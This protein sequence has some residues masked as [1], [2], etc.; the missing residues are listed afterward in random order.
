MLQASSTSPANNPNAKAK[1]LGGPEYGDVMKVQIQVNEAGVI[2]DAKFK[3]CGCGSAV[4]EELSLPPVKMDCSA[5]A[6]DAIKAAIED[7]KRKNG[8]A[9][10]EGDHAGE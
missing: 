2:T 5:L 6:E 10:A 9:P 3:T 1:I 7:W 8:Q 4:A